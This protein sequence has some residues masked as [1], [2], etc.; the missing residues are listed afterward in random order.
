MGKRLRPNHAA[1]RTGLL[2]RLRGCQTPK[3][4]TP[5]G[6]LRR[7]H[8]QVLDEAATG[9]QLRR[10]RDGLHGGAYPSHIRK[11]PA[12]WT[13]RCNHASTPRRP[14]SLGL[15]RRTSSD[16]P[17]LPRRTSICFRATGRT[18]CLYAIA[19]T[20][21]LS[22]GPSTLTMNEIPSYDVADRRRFLVLVDCLVTT[23]S[24]WIVSSIISARS[25]ESSTRE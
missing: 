13:D 7:I 23:M 25:A 24:S 18:G 16:P 9:W 17:T 3:E 1:T 21:F 10:H 6:T 11:S 12:H 8:R 20:L 5:G 22:G 19:M 2:V 15:P 14:T 4:T